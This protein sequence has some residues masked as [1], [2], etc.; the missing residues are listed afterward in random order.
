MKQ[1]QLVSQALVTGFAFIALTATA[2]WSSVPVPIEYEPET[3]AN[4]SI[5]QEREDIG[6]SQ[7]ANKLSSAS[8]DSKFKQEFAEVDAN[9]FFQNIQTCNGTLALDTPVISGQLYGEQNNMCHFSIT[10]KASVKG[11]VAMSTTCYVPMATL[12]VTFIEDNQGNNDEPDM[13]T[14]TEEQQQQVKDIYSGETLDDLGNLPSAVQFFTALE[15]FEAYCDKLQTTN[16]LTEL[17]AEYLG[18]SNNQ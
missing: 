11:T 14:L 6:V 2:G 3:P 8:V 17:K 15:K 7:E 4:T 10:L 1:L 13:A 18:E 9:T 16:K 5:S 12:L